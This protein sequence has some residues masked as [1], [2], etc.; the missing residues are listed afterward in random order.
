MFRFVMSIRKYSRMNKNLQV[1]VKSKFSFYPVTQKNWKDFEKLFGEKGACAGC[2]CMFWKLPRKDF[3]AG[4]G[5]SNRLAQKAFVTSHGTPG[6]LAYV[7]GVPVGWIAVEPRSEYPGLARSR[8]LAPLDET[9]V[10][11]VTCFFVAKKYRR[12][13]LT[14]GLLKAAVEFVRLKGGQVVEG[15][16]VEPKQEKTAPVFIYTGVSSAF[17]QAGFTEAGRRSATRPIMRFIIE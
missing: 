14:V 8:V 5:D 1:K 13:G 11:S 10:W 2:W 4:Q 9:A 17:L 15:Y 6:L 3:T 12:Q 7:D 16:P